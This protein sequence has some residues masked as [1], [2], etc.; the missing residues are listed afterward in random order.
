MISCH[1]KFETEPASNIASCTGDLSNT[2]VRLHSTKPHGPQ[3][4]ERNRCHTSLL[5][6]TLL[7]AM[8][9]MM[10]SAAKAQMAISA[11]LS[12]CDEVAGGPIRRK[13]LAI[14]IHVVQHLSYSANMIT[15]C[16][17]PHADVMLTSKLLYNV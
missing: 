6:F 12:P 16:T 4:A 17:L 2:S 3:D 8:C 7:A 1:D 5:T 14:V 9:R 13:I 15:Y 10:N 11:V